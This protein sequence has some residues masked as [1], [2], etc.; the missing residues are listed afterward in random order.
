MRLAG[1]YSNESWR[2]QDADGNAVVVRRYGRLHV[3]RGA[4]FYEHAV[5]R[6]AAAR[7]AEVCAPHADGD[8]ETLALQEGAFVAVLPYIAGQTG[9][10]DR[11]ESSGGLLARFHL[12]MRDFHAARPRATRS[13]GVLPWLRERFLTFA[14]DP[15][16][17]RALPWDELIA[18]VSGATARFARQAARLPIVVVHGD[19]HPDNVV[20][21]GDVVAG[22]I[23]FDFTHETERVY[24]VAVGLDAY[25][26]SSQDAPLEVDRLLRFLSGY[27]AHVPLLAVERA[28][29]PAA[30]VRRNAMLIW[31]IVTRHG[32]SVRGDVGGAPRYVERI[33]EVTAKKTPWPLGF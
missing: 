13:L 28:L 27:E 20:C 11:I 22:L 18:A 9:R 16:L 24:D 3:A 15:M 14:A 32:L 4:L 10:W 7:L 1:G 31:Y 23:D 17:S 21:N 29:I 6:H 5:M 2:V 19:L 30:I 25:G 12:A 26:R 33:R 8:G